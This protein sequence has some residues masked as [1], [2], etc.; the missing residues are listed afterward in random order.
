MDTLDASSAV[1]YC[2]QNS[3]MTVIVL[4]MFLINY[5]MVK[6]EYTDTCDKTNHN[7]CQPIIQ[8]QILQAQA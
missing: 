1:A 2:Q 6:F 3:H 7:H 4:I 5:K 8:L